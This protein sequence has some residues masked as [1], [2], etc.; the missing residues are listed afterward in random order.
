[1]K[2]IEFFGMPRSG[3]TP[4]VEILE[5]YFKERKAR[6][7]TVYEGARVCPLDKSDRFNYNAWSFHNTVNR[8]LE[9][10][11]DHYDIILVD[12][13][14]LDHLAFSMAIGPQCPGKDMQ[15][16][17]GYYAQFRELQD[18]EILFTV[19]VEEAIKREARHKPFVGRVFQ[20]QF[21]ERLHESYEQTF[22]IAQAREKRDIIR[23]DG[24]KPEG[25]NLK[26]VLEIAR[27]LA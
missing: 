24:N 10:R 14:I 21:L 15:T 22:R 26:K 6:V 19:D 18:L 16:A 12:R 23:I 20:N 7:R 9:A 4:A 17:S 27:D 5:S 11:M 2:V 25:E 3:K 13:G 8:I 1:M